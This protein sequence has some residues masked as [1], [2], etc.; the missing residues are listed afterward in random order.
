MIH[1]GIRAFNF[2]DD[3]KI[4]NNPELPVI[5]YEGVFK[6]AISQVEKTFNKHKWLNSWTNGIFDYHHYHNNT[7]EVLGV[8]SGMAV[9]QLGGEQGETLDLHAG[10][11][12]VL[13]A[14]TG[15][16]KLTASSDFKV[17]GA[18][19]DGTDF[20]TLTGEPGERPQVLKDIEKVP[21]PMCDPVFGE[22][23]PM[24]DRWLKG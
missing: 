16:K 1:E 7:H 6:D 14:G 19:P 11:V 2:N 5:L 23:G 21:L 17:V 24:I 3:G 4:P 22:T 15:H 9:V 20:H 18:Y 12:V 13:P 10:D 8:I